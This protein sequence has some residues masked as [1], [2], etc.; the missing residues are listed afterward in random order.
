MYNAWQFQRVQRSGAVG[1]MEVFL[2]EPDVSSLARHA[3][4]AE[5]A[6][7]ALPV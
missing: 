1:A 7:K 5:A 4:K 2:D 3:L 6:W